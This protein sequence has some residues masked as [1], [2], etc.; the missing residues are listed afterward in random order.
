MV[1]ILTDVEITFFTQN[2]PVNNHTKL[3]RHFVGQ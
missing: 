1:E 3:G 2:E